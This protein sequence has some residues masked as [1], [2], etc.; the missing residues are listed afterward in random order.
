MSILELKD[1]SYTYEDGTAVL[2]NISFTFDE[3]KIYAVIG[4]SGAGKTTLLSLLSGLA[5]PTQGQILCSTD[6]EI[7]GI[8]TYFY[9]SHNVGVIFQS[10]NLLPNLTA[11]ENVVLSMEIAGI[12]KKERE[13]KA[14]QLLEKVGLDSEE[15]HRRV[16]KAFRRA[17]A[18]SCHRQSPFL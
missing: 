5:F 18:E 6:K 16:F 12:Q 1:V 7:T 4:R 17:A 10:Y 2:K 9:R 11:L 3:G 15:A 14:M 8:D 13:Q